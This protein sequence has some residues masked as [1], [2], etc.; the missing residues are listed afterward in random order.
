LILSTGTRF[1]PGF[2]TVDK[3]LLEALGKMPAGTVEMYGENLDIVRFPTERFGHVFKEYLTEK[4][5]ENPPD[6]I[7][8]VYVGNL[9]TS[10][11][12]LEQLFPGKPV[13]VAGFTEE[14][15][16]PKQFSNIVSGVA[17]RVDP[18]ASI[19]LILRLQPETRRIV[20][21]AGTV[22]VDRQVVNRV[23]EAATSF[24]GQ[25]EFEFWDNRTVAELRQG[26]SAL[27]AR[28][29]ILF[30]RMFRDSAGQPVISS[31]MGQL[32]GQW[33]NVPVYVMTDTSLGTGAVGGAVA[34]VEAF[35]R[36][37]GELARLILTGTD[38]QSLPFE[39]RTDSVPTFD[40]RALKRWGI[41]EHR[42]P[43]NSDVRYKPQT[44]WGEYRWYI[45]AVL[46][47]LLVQSVI[48][49]DLLIERRRRLRM[50]RELHESREMIDLAASAGGL[51]L[52][53]RDL[54]SGVVWANATL[55]SL[56]GLEK[57]DP[58]QMTDVF[59]Y[60]H[61]E[62]R[63]RVIEQMR[64]AEQ[65]DLPFEGE[66][67][68]VLPDKTVRWLL[69]KGRSVPTNEVQGRRRMGVV[70]DI[71]ERKRAEAALEKERAFLRE[72][73]DAVPNFIFAKDRDGRFTLANRAL[74]DAYGTTVEDLIGKTDA[75]FNTNR[76]EVEFFRRVDREVIDA[77]VERFI[78]EEHMTDAQGQVR[79]LQTVKRPIMRNGSA[80]EIL[81]ASTDITRRKETEIQ[82]QEL[83]AELAHVARISTMGELAASLAHELN[84]PLTAML[85]NAQAALRFLANNPADIEEVR[86]ILE[87]I[88][89]DNNRAGEVIRR[90]RMMVKKENVEFIPLNIASLIRE[91]IDLSHSDAIFQDVQ[92]SLRLDDNLPPVL[93][94][95]VQLQQ[96]VL[97]LLLNAFD[98]MRSR[99]AAERRVSIKT[100]LYVDRM[101]RVSVRDSGTGL[102]EKLDKIIGPFYTTKPEG[103]GIGLSICR[104]II[105]THN[106]HLWAEDNAAER[107]AT[108]YFTVPVAKSALSGE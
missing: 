22:E 26:V 25:V 45:V 92:I 66:A 100:D 7:I 50:Q 71:T 97:N 6:L 82:L 65:G 107:G 28:T 14:E 74:A 78:P 29:A 81:G 99:P 101:I 11:K 57:T 104:S 55:R 59:E 5:V 43:Q 87:D 63:A 36:R 85:S 56:V 69:A 98:A 20:V 61:P 19:E 75:D 17:Q 88:V 48:I 79:W 8:L 72:V 103:M 80:Q 42:L 3:G 13:V 44:F 102:T 70:L 53:A 32:I 89:A 41:A 21:V 62:E 31:Q 64:R 35:G 18:R 77:S 30:T 91:V 67:R 93:G 76:V 54:K 9:G 90:M 27:P 4:Y 68:I 33:A 16:Q 46:F 2:A 83:R 10:G 108:F 84:Q 34:S 94:D 15:V 24:K 58:I 38:P 95:R 96:V 12:L 51:G 52:W 73:I 105:E 106:G 86:E 23:K 37:T 40:W 39:L 1:A 60:F 49:I 47:L